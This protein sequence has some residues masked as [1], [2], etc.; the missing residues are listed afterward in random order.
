M[1][2]RIKRTIL[3][4]RMPTRM[5]MIKTVISSLLVTMSRTPTIMSTSKFACDVDPFGSGFILVGGSGPRD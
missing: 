5:T 2:P 3:Q 4:I 1:Q